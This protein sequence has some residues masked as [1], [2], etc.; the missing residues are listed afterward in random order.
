MMT[1]STGVKGWIHTNQI[2]PGYIETNVSLVQGYQCY[3]TPIHHLL[4]IKVVL[5]YRD[6][7]SLSKSK[8]CFILVPPT[9][10]VM[11]CFLSK[12]TAIRSDYFRK[13]I[14]KV[15][16]I[17]LHLG[18]IITIGHVTLVVIT[19]TINLVPYAKVKSL[20]LSFPWVSARKT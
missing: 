19:G 5:L 2:M 8:S 4:Q 3:F 13:K 14:I 6:C 12:Q 9:P 16:K 1:V 15:H 17:K 7:K 18:D 20:K 10:P 11:R